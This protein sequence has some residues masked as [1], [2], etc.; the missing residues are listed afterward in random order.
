MAGGKSTRMGGRN[1]ALLRLEG[2]TFLEQ[3]ALQLCHFDELLLSVDD[4]APFMNCGM[5]IVRDIYRGYGAMSGLHSA[6]RQCT[7]DAM[8]VVPCDMPLFKK[9]LA[10]YVLEFVN[11][12]ADAYIVTTSD[13]RPVP[14]CGIYTKSCAAKMQR[15]IAKGDYS[16]EG[17]LET[18]VVRKVPLAYTYFGDEIV[19]TVNTPDEYREMQNMLFGPP[20]IAI[21]G[22]KG[23]GK[24]QMLENVLPIL[25]NYGLKA[26]VIKYNGSDFVPE[27]SGT[28]SSRYRLAGAN[29]VAVYSDH[30]YMVMQ[31]YESSDAQA[32]LPFFWQ[33]D[34]VLLEGGDDSP[35]AKIEIAG[36]DKQRLPTCTNGTLLAFSAKMPD[37]KW[38]GKLLGYEDYEA[39]AAFIMEFV[40]GE[41][42][43]EQV[44]KAGKQNEPVAGQTGT[45]PEAEEPQKPVATQAPPTAAAPQEGAGTTAPGAQRQPETQGAAVKVEPEKGAAYNLDKP[46]EEPVENAPTEAVQ[47]VQQDYVFASHF[48]DVDDLFGDFRE[49][50]ASG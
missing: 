35:F 44:R 10:D 46:A 5:K 45:A 1:K 13:G 39:M 50:K 28:D 25:G 8:F 3:I 20:V 17:L 31:E 37:P 33:T 42:N 2:R 16:V 36:D 41:E 18:L 23:A 43:A 9:E 27:K 14:L 30:R 21:T 4:A 22:T 34:V 26:G 19:Y 47:P 48:E 40:L 15:Q 6:L 24:T 29:P 38:A 12:E 49:A 7:S 11:G 32:L